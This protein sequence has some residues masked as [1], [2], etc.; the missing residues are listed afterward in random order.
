M[1]KQRVSSHVSVGLVSM[2]RP[3]NWSRSGVKTCPTWQFDLPVRKSINTKTMSDSEGHMRNFQV[4]SDEIPPTDEEGTVVSA[5]PAGWGKC[6]WQ[7]WA[8]MCFHN[9]FRKMVG[10]DSK[11]SVTTLLELNKL[12]VLVETFWLDT[13]RQLGLA[14]FHWL[15]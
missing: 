14:F 1:L 10:A 8:L 7:H 3:G 4:V 11:P 13:T 9:N 12:Y 6:N 5:G 15:I 2:S